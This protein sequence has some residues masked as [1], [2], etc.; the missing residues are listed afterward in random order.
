MKGIFAGTLFFLSIISAFA[1]LKKCEVI[2]NDGRTITGLMKYFKKGVD[3]S[4]GFLLVDSLG[5]EIKI[6]PQDFTDLITKGQK[7]KSINDRKGK[8]RFMEEIVE[9]SRAS[10]YTYSTSYTFND[11]NF[12]MTSGGVTQY[13]MKRG[14]AIFFVDRNNLLRYP[15]K[16]YPGNDKLIEKIKRTK[17]K[18]Y[19]IV[20]WTLVYNNE[21]KI[22]DL[23]N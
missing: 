20:L 21:I 10:L 2:S 3:V 22:S 17:K 15:E 5:R 23:P 16:Y 1:Q 7:F 11:P 18:N 9:G 8:R 6:L 14:Q 19:E 4:D 12:G 13:F